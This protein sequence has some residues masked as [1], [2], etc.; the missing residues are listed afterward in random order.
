LALQGLSSGT[1]YY[2]NWGYT[3]DVTTIMMDM[4]G[5]IKD[6]ILSLSGI[7]LTAFINICSYFTSPFSIE[8]RLV[9]IV[10][11]YRRRELNRVDLINMFIE[12]ESLISSFSQI[13]I[14][15]ISKETAID[16]LLLEGLIEK[17]SLKMALSSRVNINEGLQGQ[18]LPFAFSQIPTTLYLSP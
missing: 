17:C 1:K 12:D 7:D 11:R 15:K 14:E 13:D 18:V 2:R 5:P 9:D 16:K 4:V 10:E 8:G 3:Q 6:H